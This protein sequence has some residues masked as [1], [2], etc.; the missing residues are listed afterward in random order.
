MKTDDRIATLTLNPSIDHILTVDK[1]SM[2][3]KNI[4]TGKQTYYGGKGINVA[5]TLGKLGVPAT[6]AG[7]IGARDLDGVKRKLSEVGIIN[8]F[9]PFNGSTRSTYK[10]MESA[11]NHDTEFNQAGSRVSKKCLDDLVSQFHDL[12]NTHSWLMLCGSIPSGIPTDFYASLIERCKQSGAVTC[13]D[14]SG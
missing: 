2:Y 7:L 8:A 3:N 4:L 10:I 13:L 1:L 5:F 14:T 12:L 6:A 11:T 9:I